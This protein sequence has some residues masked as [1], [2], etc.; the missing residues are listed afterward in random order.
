MNKR[1]SYDIF[2][3]KYDSSGN[4]QWTKAFGGS[5]N[6]W[7]YSVATDSSGNVYIT[8]VFQTTVDFDPG[9]G[10]DNR[11][12][13][14]SNDTFLSKYDASGNYQWTRAFGGT[15]SDLVYS[16]ATDSSGNVY[17]AGY[18]R[19]TVDFDPGAGVDNRTSAGECDAF[20]S[21]Y[22]ASGNYQWTK[23]FG[24]TGSDAADSVARQ[25]W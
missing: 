8:G 21:K 10:V 12:S 13:A 2:V 24:G 4:Y 5:G 17:I 3:S 18:F 9:A 22:D 19:N 23:A 6:D 25:Q 11:T 1:G 15:G 20:L 7:A 14:G 16:V